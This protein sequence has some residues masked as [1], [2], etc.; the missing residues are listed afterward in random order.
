[1]SRIL[2]VVEWLDIVVIY[3]WEDA[4]EIMNTNPVKV[5]SV[6]YIIYKDDKKLI[7][8]HGA[9]D[10][11]EGNPHTII[12]MGCVEN[13]KYVSGFTSAPPEETFGPLSDSPA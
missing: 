6:G 2:A 10:N 8:R 12:P 1:M 3:G 13:I 4:A 5:E 7:L 11:G 9:G